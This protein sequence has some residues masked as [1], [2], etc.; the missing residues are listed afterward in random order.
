MLMSYVE[1][2]WALH[3]MLR[4]QCLHCPIHTLCYMLLTD[5]S[6]LINHIHTLSCHPKSV[7]LIPAA[8]WS[9]SS[10]CAWFIASPMLM[11]FHDLLRIPSP[12]VGFSEAVQVL[13]L[14][15]E[16]II[17]KTITRNWAF[18]SISIMG[19]ACDHNKTPM[20]WRL[21]SSPHSRHTQ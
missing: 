8:G 19:A 3:T 16:R 15:L 5:Q 13:N 4:A 9:M 10:M 11:I 6:C 21:N 17:W 20:C 2:Y 14:M 18:F 1:V 12:A 7:S